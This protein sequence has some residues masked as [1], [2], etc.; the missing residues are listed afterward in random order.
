MLCQGHIFQ[1]LLF[2][3]NFLEYTLGIQELS[4]L[5]KSNKFQMIL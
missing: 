1:D 5:Y 2:P 3:H 4:D